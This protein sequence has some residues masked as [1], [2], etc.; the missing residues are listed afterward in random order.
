MGRP[1]VHHTAPYKTNWPNSIDWNPSNFSILI[2]ADKVELAWAPV[3]LIL[4][5]PVQQKMRLYGTMYA[6]R[7]KS[8]GDPQKLVSL[9]HGAVC[10]QVGSRWSEVMI[11]VVSRGAI[12]LWFCCHPRRSGSIVQLPADDLMP[13]WPLFY[14]HQ[15]CSW[16]IMA[17]REHQMDKATSPDVCQPLYRQYLSLTFSHGTKPTSELR[18]EQHHYQSLINN[19]WSPTCGPRSC[20]PPHNNIPSAV[21][22]H[23]NFHFLPRRTIIDY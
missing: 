12:M 1:H 7:V 5:A 19:T 14:S 6:C 10:Q 2:I 20:C 8:A 23:Q 17:A 16:L 18:L 3:G 22:V 21:L 13:C 15:T 4:R 9:W 11:L